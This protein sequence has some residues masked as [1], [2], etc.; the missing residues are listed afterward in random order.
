[1]EIRIHRPRHATI[2]AYLALF[3]AGTGTAAAAT[4][5]TFVLGRSNA[6]T[7]VTSLSNSNGTALSL[8]S[9]TGTP[10]LAVSSSTKVTRLN[11]DSL[12][13]LDSS[14]FQRKTIGSCTTALK[15][16]GQNGATT[17]ATAPKLTTTI[18]T[19][20]ISNL[21]GSAKC[22]SGT[23]LTGGGYQLPFQGDPAKHDYVRQS[24][25]TQSGIGGA[26]DTWTV[27]LDPTAASNYQVNVPS[28]VYAICT[29][30]S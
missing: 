23:V 7:T 10:P 18:V 1:M 29:A 4:G 9:K 26:Y 2:V 27:V 5:G 19:A 8:S 21:G 20:Q 15:S 17:C 16:I 13:G 14:S 25:P 6:A 30:I 28:T 22:P 11:S 3:V 12:D 24:A